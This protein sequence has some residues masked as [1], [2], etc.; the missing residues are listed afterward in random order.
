MSKT[1]EYNSDVQQKITELHKLESGCKKISKALK[2]PFSTINMLQICL[3]E[4]LCL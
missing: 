1:K 3:E 2:M 4:D